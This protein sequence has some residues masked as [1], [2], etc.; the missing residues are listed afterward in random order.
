MAFAAQC[1]QTNT[2]FST[3]RSHRSLAG[4]VAVTALPRPLCSSTQRF[5][6]VPCRLGRSVVTA[7]TNSGAQD[8][9][10]GVPRDADMRRVGNEQV[11][12]ELVDLVNRQIQSRGKGRRRAMTYD[13]ASPSFKKYVDN[14]TMRDILRQRLAQDKAEAAALHRESTEA[15]AR[16]KEEALADLHRTVKEQLDELAVDRAEHAKLKAQYFKSTRDTVREMYSRQG[17]FDGSHI[18]NFPTG[19][20]STP[21][22]MLV[23]PPT[24]LHLSSY[25]IPACFA[26]C[27]K[28]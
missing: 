12:D 7:A 21:E 16:A 14:E 24:P 13:D 19:P 10:D 28:G 15:I 6:C 1:S 11:Q 25:L 27:C 26:P 22:G 18:Y 17:G 4:H 9:E 2:A 8:N 23:C 5:Q 20:N 3:V